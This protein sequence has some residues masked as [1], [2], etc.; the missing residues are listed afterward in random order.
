M[1]RANSPS[2]LALGAM[3]NVDNLRGPDAFLTVDFV[4]SRPLCDIPQIPASIWQIHRG[5]SPV[6]RLLNDPTQGVTDLTRITREA[7]VRAGM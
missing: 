7:I 3:F 6:G 5:T 2:L 1:L 4:T